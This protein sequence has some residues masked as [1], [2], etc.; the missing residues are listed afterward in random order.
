MQ[1]LFNSPKLNKVREVASDTDV[2]CQSTFKS[3][4]ERQ[5]KGK[6]G[7]S[8]A[9]YRQE[10]PFDVR[11]TLMERGGWEVTLTLRQAAQ[12]RSLLVCKCRK[13]FSA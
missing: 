13:G 11:D 3:F 9:M 10:V 2:R 1:L 7:P 5:R 12:V 4:E 8:L 6:P